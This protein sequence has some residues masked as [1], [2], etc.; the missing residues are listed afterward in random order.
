M[1]SSRLR[2]TTKIVRSIV[3]KHHHED[4]TASVGSK[5]KVVKVLCYDTTSWVK[6]NFDPQVSVRIV[7]FTF[8]FRFS[9]ARCCLK[10]FLTNGQ[11]KAF[12][13]G[14]KDLTLKVDFTQDRLDAHTA[15][16]AVGYD[17]ICLFVNDTADS[18]T[19]LALSMCG[20]RLKFNI[21][22]IF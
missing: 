5:K 9:T 3:E 20:V 19:L 8:K 6:E 22:I 21:N 17:A 13:E 15:K 12:N 11:V 2:S 18:K 10:R 1:I 16:F 7:Q 4:E 14:G